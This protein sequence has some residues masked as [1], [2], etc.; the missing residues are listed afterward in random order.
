MSELVR[1]RCPGHHLMIYRVLDEI[2]RMSLK[3]RPIIFEHVFTT[4]N[5]LKLA[6]FRM[7]KLRVPK[8]SCS[9]VKPKI[10]L[11][12]GTN[13]KNTDCKAFP[14]RFYTVQGIGD[15]YYGDLR[16]IF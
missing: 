9:G 2:I 15:G 16:I 8:H 1:R 3:K 6:C 4:N 13:V 14:A 12:K 11:F 10:T 5:T 7:K